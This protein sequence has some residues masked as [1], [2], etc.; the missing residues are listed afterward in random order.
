MRKRQKKTK[1]E[2]K[3][4]WKSYSTFSMRFRVS[5]NIYIKESFTH[6][7]WKKKKTKQVTLPLYLGIS[8]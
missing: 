2:K 8:W 4:T 7:L 3:N 6:F 1:T 5:V